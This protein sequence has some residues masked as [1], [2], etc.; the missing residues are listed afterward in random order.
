MGDPVEA[1]S[2][3]N[4]GLVAMDV[5]LVSM[6]EVKFV[7]MDVVLV[8]IDMDEVELVAMDVVAV[9]EVELLF[10]LQQPNTFMSS[11]LNL[12]PVI[13]YNTALIL[14]FRYCSRISGAI[15]ILGR[16]PPYIAQPMAMGQVKIIN[17]VD[18]VT[19]MTVPLTADL[20]RA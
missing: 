18:T 1:T 7:T 2:L 4:V 14:W 8:T 13:Q 17:A 19:N 10:G 9:D 12:D 16:V 3:V 15:T 20:L 11:C 6:D 5:E